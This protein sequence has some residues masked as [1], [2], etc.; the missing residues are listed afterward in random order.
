MGYGFFDYK[1][2]IDYH[3]E[4]FDSFYR[5][6]FIIFVLV[7]SF[8]L[9]YIFRKTKK[10][11]MIKYL[12]II[13]V[14]MTLL[15][16]I[17]VTWESYFDITTGHGFNSSGVLSLETCSLFM[18]TSLVAGYTKCEKVRRSCICWLVTIGLVAGLSNTIFPQGLKW[19]PFFTF[20]AF[21]SLF[22]HYI[23][24]LTALLLIFNRFYDFEYKD[25][26]RGFIPHLI[27]SIFVIILD[28]I[29]KWNYMLYRDPSAF[30]VVSLITDKLTLKGLYFINTIIV[31]IMF[32]VLDA[33]FMSIYINSYKL[34][35]KINENKSLNIKEIPV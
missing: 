6:G 12:K 27:F 25:I 16:V 3:G 22:Y 33:L 29:M 19:Y 17:K 1:Y 15:E 24:V 13:S 14:V 26:I 28:Y 8:V 18:Y 7:S 9:S 30:P 21:H 4:D 5:T 11:N 23:L 34:I 10:E 35:D 31:F 32:F 2:N 20:G